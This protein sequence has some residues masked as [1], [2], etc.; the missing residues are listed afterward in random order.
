MVKPQIN[1]NQT[2]KEA[3]ELVE[4]PMVEMEL[5]ILEAVV[6]AVAI[7]VLMVVQAD[8]E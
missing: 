8:Q 1:H 2:D 4:L 6:V 5:L 7:M 3:V